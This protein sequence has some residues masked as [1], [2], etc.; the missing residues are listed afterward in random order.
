MNRQSA[1][2]RTDF[3]YPGRLDEK[4]DSHYGR[5][6]FEIHGLEDRERFF[7]LFQIKPGLYLSV[8]NHSPVGI[9]SMAFEVKNSPVSFSF[10]VSGTYRLRIRG[11]GFGKAVELNLFPDTNAVT[12]LQD[13]SGDVCFKTDIPLICVELIIDR[14][15]L[16]TY[17][18]D[19][20]DRLHHS[21]AGLFDPKQQVYATFPLCREMAQTAMEIVNPPDYTGVTLALFHESRALNLLALQLEHLTDRAH[22]FCTDCGSLYPRTEDTDLERLYKAR[23][24]LVSDLKN[25]PTIAALARQCGMNEFKLKKEFKQVFNTTIFAHLQHVK[26]KKAWHLLIEGS[27]SVTE[28]AGEVGYTNISHF[29][30]AFK[31]QFQ[32]NPGSLKK[33]RNL[34]HSLIPP[35]PEKVACQNGSG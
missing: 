30:A 15:L 5:P 24:I 32:I 13:I 20:I 35:E 25:P 26:M 28:T 11:K 31:K 33:A 2:F 27:R 6:A 12:A 1:F 19:K 16:Y 23:Q 7:K 14:R 18:K 8:Y 4:T 29:S 3:T 9:P 10:L 22:P 17:L 21:V 34:G